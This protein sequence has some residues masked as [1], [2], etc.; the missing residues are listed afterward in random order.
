MPTGSRAATKRPSRPA[1]TN[2]NMPLSSPSPSIPRSSIRCSATSLSE[3]VSSSRSTRPGADLLVVVDLAV[4]DEVGALVAGA[5]RLLAAAHVDDREPAVP[6]P[7]AVELHRAAVVGPAMREPLEHPLQ[8]FGI[9][10]SV[11]RDDAAHGLSVTT[12]SLSERSRARSPRAAAARRHPGAGRRGGRCRG[13]SRGP[14]RGRPRR[15]RGPRRR[16]WS[17]S[18][19]PLGSTTLAEPR[20]R[21]GPHGPVWLADTTKTWFSTARVWSQRSKWRVWTSSRMSARGVHAIGGPRRQRADDVGAVEGE[22]A[23]RL[24]EELVVTEQHPDPADRGVEGGEAVAR[25]V[26]EALGGRQVDLALVAEHAVAADA[27]GRRVE[28]PSPASV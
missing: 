6:E 28:P 22:R 2:A 10:A 1:I 23:R 26:G 7:A 21:S 9:R 25:G 18:T 20:K 5:Q 15:P 4:A 19:A 11:L 8:R 24:G 17:A 3:V 13:G 12:R 14:R 16:R 27:D